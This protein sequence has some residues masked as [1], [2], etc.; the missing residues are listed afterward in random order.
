VLLVC[1]PLVYS[2]DFGVNFLDDPQFRAEHQLSGP[3]GWP[4]PSHY[5]HD[6]TLC[7]TH[8]NDKT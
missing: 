7:P 1:I 5:L 4:S 8:H 3:T 6:E 2:W